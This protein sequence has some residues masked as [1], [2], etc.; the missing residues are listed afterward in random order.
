MTTG[1][2]DRKTLTP[3]E[4]AISSI[5]SES[6]G[7]VTHLRGSV[8]ME[9]ASMLVKAD[10][11][12]YDQETY[13][14]TARGHVY[15]HD[16]DRNEQVWCERMVY[17][18]K[19]QTGTFEGGVRG[20]SQPKVVVRPGVLSGNSPF[21]FEGEWAER[22][23]DRYT[24][25][26]GW[27]TNCKLPNPWWRL[28]GPK[29]VIIPG[30]HANAY[31]STFVL[32][33]VPVFWFPFFYHSL[34]KE[35]RKSGFLVPSLVPRSRRGFMAG[36]GY[37]WAINRSYDVTY[38]LLD[39]N[40]N[41]LEHEVDFRGKPTARSDFDLIFTGVND[42]GG[43][44]G[45]GT[46]A[47]KYSGANV[48]FTGRYDLGNGWTANSLVNYV[49]SFR[50]RQEWSAGYNEAIGSEIHSAGFLNKNWSSYTLDISAE[51]TENFQTAEIQH[52]NPDGS[53]SYERNAVL[54]H[55][56]PEADFSGRDRQPLPD[57]P[58][59][60]SFDSSAGL[61]YRSEPV[62][63]AGNQLINT[64]ETSQFTPRMNFSP[65][66]M[67]AFHFAGMDFSPSFQLDETYYGESQN[68]QLNPAL[69]MNLYRVQQ[70]SITRSARELSLDIALPS[71]ARVFDK[72][73]IFGD[74]LKHVIEPRVTY[75]YVT[76]IGTNFDRIIRFDEGD[77]LTNTNQLTLSLTNRIYAKRGDNVSEIFT[78]ELTQDR[79]FD[80]T[81]GGALIPYSRNVFAA[82]ADVTAYSFLDEVRGTSPVA[83]VLRASPINGLS[84]QW[85]LDYDPRYR[86][87]VDSSFSV[88]YSWKKYHVTVGDN[89]VHD[90]P[91]LVP[92][93]NPFNLTG[94]PINFFPT[95]PG[96]QFNFSAGFGDPQKR[97]W[98]AA[99][100]VAYDIRQ[101]K[102][103]YNT[104]Q[105]TYNTD[106]CGF[107][108]EYRRINAGLR[109]ESR[110]TMS[111]SLANIG[112]F[113][114][115]RKQDRLF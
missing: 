26:N 80:P 41:A 64:F 68:I 108:V 49:S 36:L 104:T 42:F 27:V 53:F 114:T 65:R 32:K 69:A 110:V 106:C 105:V 73:T 88:G 5:T 93:G 14:L 18:T 59:W 71:F 84:V 54:I 15:L 113:G 74:K 63:D 82:T 75:K 58:L 40:T 52:T 23:E 92:V 21:H 37:Y 51:R 9:N 6:D 79:Y 39:Y 22:V 67:S 8:Q 10:E 44:P 57:L 77:I 50:F 31:D 101:S 33:K 61:L 111:F 11:A 24:V 20:E 43:D 107:S 109:D 62:F 25:H 96:N 98:N 38:R 99:T 81:F 28:K 45:S 89:D 78:W 29:F 47:Q 100:S 115:L 97:G 102:F 90:T 60:F 95:P 103:L 46:P 94:N 83:S 86:R 76:G 13:E 55:K 16:F 34:A 30:D 3:N 12:D 35:P 17:N 48:Y 70:T 72:K 112:T 85:L 87:L 66:V 56:L 1:L 91:I 2:P 7:T 19:T 4:W